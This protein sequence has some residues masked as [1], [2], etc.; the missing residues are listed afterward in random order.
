MFV[1]IYLLKHPWDSLCSSQLRLT[2]CVP[3]GHGLFGNIVCTDIDKMAGADGKAGRSLGLSSFVPVK[4]N[5]SV[6]GARSED[7][8]SES[9]YEPEYD[10]DLEDES[11][12]RPWERSRSGQ[13]SSNNSWWQ[14]K[15]E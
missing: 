14:Q 3:E 12:V 1:F 10:W 15:K 8:Q 7:E 4:A 13:L 5:G 6:Q 9:W 2:V 11:F